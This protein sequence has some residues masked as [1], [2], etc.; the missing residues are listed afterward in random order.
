MKMTQHQMMTGRRTFQFYHK[1]PFRVDQRIHAL[2]LAA[3]RKRE[4]SNRPNLSIVL[5]FHFLTLVT[6]TI[7]D[8][9][10]RYDHFAN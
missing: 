1:D 3:L 7:V 8:I 6:S 9:D 5:D 4:F 10:I 2:F